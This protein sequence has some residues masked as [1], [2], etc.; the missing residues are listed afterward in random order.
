MICERCREQIPEVLAGKL[1]KAARDAVIEHMETCSACRAEMAEL[2]VVWRGLETLAVPAA[3]PLPAMR[4]RFLELL[5]AYESGFEAGKVA[6]LPPPPKPAPARVESRPWFA[7]LHPAWRMAMAA[8]LLALGVFGGKLVFQPRGENPE[9]AQLKGQ[10]EGLRQLVALSLLQDQSAGSRLRGVTYSLQMTQPD[11][12]VL[13]SLLHTLNSDTNINVR[14]R[15]V[16]ALEKYATDPQ[17]RRALED[18][19]PLQDSPLVQA[20]LIDLLVQLNDKDSSVALAKLAADS[21]VDPVVRA[22]ASAAIQKLGLKKEEMS[23]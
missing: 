8:V 16:D 14:L 7:V 13:Q 17:V 23:H 5:H 1:D 2:G 10:V 22:R 19:L 15:T 18:S 6:Q 4:N 3:E 21:Q 11:G 9:M 20:S 12:Q